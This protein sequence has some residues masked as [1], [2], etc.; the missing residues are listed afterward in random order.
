MRFHSSP[1]ARWL[2]HCILIPLLNTG[3]DRR[4][5]KLQL[6]RRQEFS[7]ALRL[8]IPSMHH[9]ALN[10]TT[11]PKLWCSVALVLCG[12][13][14]PLRRHYAW[15]L[16]TEHQSGAPWLNWQSRGIVKGN[17]LTTEHQSTR[18]F[19][20]VRFPRIVPAALKA[21]HRAL[22]DKREKL[23]PLLQRVNAKCLANLP[24]A[25]SYVIFGQ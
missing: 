23:L 3:P 8:K 5:R 4:K 13:F 1:C 11:K 12:L 15:N 7:G 9:R 21:R 19:P 22:A 20:V 10:L 14:F 6:T 24:K 17:S 2:N 16:T 18:E 25:G